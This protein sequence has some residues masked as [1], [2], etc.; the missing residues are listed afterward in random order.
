M[1]TSGN[2]FQDEPVSEATGEP[3]PHPSTRHCGGVLLSRHRIVEGAVQV[4]EWNIDSH[5]GNRVF[6]LAGFG[7]TR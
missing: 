4:T 1:I 3:Y 2:P 7:H 6:E 5:P